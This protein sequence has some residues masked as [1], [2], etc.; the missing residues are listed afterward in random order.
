MRILF[1]FLLVLVSSMDDYYE[2]HHMPSE[3]ERI[4]TPEFM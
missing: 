2:H 3:F 1:V 4:L